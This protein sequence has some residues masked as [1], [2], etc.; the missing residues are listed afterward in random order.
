MGILLLF[1]TVG[2]LYWA[3]LTHREGWA[4]TFAIASF[5]VTL[6]LASGG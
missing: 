2:G 5:F 3:V 4:Y 1:G 6:S